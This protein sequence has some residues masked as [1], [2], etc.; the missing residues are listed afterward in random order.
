MVIKKHLEECSIRDVNDMNKGGVMIK[1]GIN[2]KEIKY[3]NPVFL[4]R[5]VDKDYPGL[6]P[7]SGPLT[8]I[9]NVV[10]A[11]FQKIRGI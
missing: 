5:T 3:R 8:L 11:F 2:G 7:S 1:D 4:M 10:K 6:G 9:T